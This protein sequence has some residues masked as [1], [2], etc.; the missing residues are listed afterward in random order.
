M[1][2]LRCLQ[3]AATLAGIA[4]A[5]PVLAL[6]PL[7]EQSLSEVTG[8][9]QGLRY[10][11]EYDARIDSVSY[12]DDDGLLGGDVG[13]ITLS[14]VRIYTQ[15][16][17]PVQID[18][19]V[20]EVGGRKALVFTNRDLPIEMEVGSV[21]INGNSLGGFGQGHFQIGSNDALVTTLYAGGSAGNGLTLD[22]DIPASMSYE[23]WIED[24]DS[25]ARLI[26][27]IDFSDPRNPAA[28]GLNLKNLTFDLD[29][30]GLRVGLPE[31]TGGTINFYNVRIGQ[32][33]L[34]SIAMRNIVFM[35][36]GYLLVKNARGHDE[37]GLEMDLK[38]SQDSAF[39]Y[40]YITGEVGADYPS[41]N[42]F[43]M[44]ANIRLL[45]DLTV[46]GMRMNVDG[47]RGLV[48]DFDNTNAQHGV[49]ANLLVSDFTMQRSDRVGV[50][51]NPV[52]LGTL[53]IQMNL[54][55]NTYLQVE[56][57]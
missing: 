57:H 5:Y 25:G 13:T 42:I 37:I 50:V 19:E 56:G 24:V 10:T 4:A 45:S 22:L 32:D 28:G 36:G 1:A 54:T 30:E 17:R 48:F 29:A 44:S 34:N 53:D 6:Q 12:I 7:D 2:S 9:A 16:N 21:A 35:P 8:Q 3:L 55:S 26:T 11:S 46:K 38:I 20:K 15:T 49:S 14:P 27:T 33:V 23:N 51:Q 41:E 52:S 18:L 39:D 40:Y 43:E 31:T 47:E